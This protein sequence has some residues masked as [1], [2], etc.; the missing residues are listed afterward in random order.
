MGLLAT[1]VISFRNS[2]IRSES[3]KYLVFNQMR[4]G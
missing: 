1:S 3:R 4:E 2:Y